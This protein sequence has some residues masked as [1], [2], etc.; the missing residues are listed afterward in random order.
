MQVGNIVIVKQ[1]WQMFAGDLVDV[2]RHHARAV[3]HLITKIQRFRLLFRV[4]PDNRH[5]VSGVGIQY[6]VDLPVQFSAG[7]RHQFFS[8]DFAERGTNAVDMNRV[9]RRFQA[10]VFPDADLRQQYAAVLGND[11]ANAAYTL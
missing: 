10:E 8:L 6:A 2:R 11:L 5:A 1:I 7:N 9:L 4:D 3:N